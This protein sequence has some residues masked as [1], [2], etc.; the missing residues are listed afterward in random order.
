LAV[1]LA[2]ETYQAV[3]LDIEGTT[4]PIEFVS[5]VLFPFARKQFR[6]FI[7]K[8]GG[9]EEVH[10]D[11]E[12]LWRQYQADVRQ[13]LQPPTWHGDLSG[14]DLES[15]VSYIHWLMDQD[16]KAT[17]LK[18]LQGR[19]WLAGYQSGELK[20]QI[21]SDVPPAFRAWAQQ[22]KG[23]CIFSSGSVLAQKLLFESTTEGDLT[24]FIRAYFDTTT[25]AKG[26]SES[27][28]RIA[29]ELNLPPSTI[30]FV[31]DVTEELDA[32]QSTEM[33]TVLCV[34]PG[35]ERPDNPGHPLIHTFEELF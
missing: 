32:A 35:R 24:R 22:K 30:V 7:Q 18:S 33:Q 34:R 6:A 19:I 12:V 16:R 23:I 11:L 3:L 28:R 2:R 17:A 20:G 1:P 10:S 8:L 5:E 26:E 15:I 25:G 4:T 21:Y 29:A 14:R 13:N 9:N 31:S 27:Y